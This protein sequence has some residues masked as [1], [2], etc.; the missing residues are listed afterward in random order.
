MQKVLKMGFTVKVGLLLVLAGVA[1][2]LWFGQ[3]A[4]AQLRSAGVVGTGTPASCTESAFT[5]TLA[6]GGSLTFNCG[7]QPFT[8]TL[9]QRANVV[10]NTVIDG[11]GLATISGGNST[12]LFDV[13]I[14]NSVKFGIQNLTLAN[15]LSPDQGAA[16][17]S[18][19]GTTLT[20]TNSIFINNVT[21]AATTGF[22]GGGAIFLDVGATGS[23]VGSSFINNTAGNG[24]AIKNNGSLTVNGSTFVGNKSTASGIGASSNGGGG[25]LYNNSGNLLVSSSVI[26]KNSAIFQGGGIMSFQAGPNANLTTV[27][28]TTLANNSVTGGAAT[29]GFGGGIYNGAGPL[30]LSNSAL[31]G[32]NASNQG[33]GIWHSDAPANFTNVTF[34]NNQAVGADGMRGLGGGIFSTRSVITNTNVTIASNYAGFQGGGVA[35]DTNIIFRNTIIANNIG[36]NNGL[37][38]NVKNN[39]TNTYTNGGNNLQFPP[40][41]PNNPDD[42]D[43]APNIM[44][45]DPRLGLPLNNG[46]LTPTLAL[47]GGSPAIDAGNSALCPP[48]DQRGA[49]RVNVCDIG[50]FEYGANLPTGPAAPTYTYYLPFL[51]ANYAPSGQTGSFTTYLVFQNVGTGTAAI[52]LQYFDNNGASINTPAATCR[53]VQQN[54]ECIAPNPFAN[55]ARGSGVLVSTQPLNVVVAQA[56]PFGGSAYVVGAGAGSQLIAPLAINNNGGFQTQLTVFNGGGSPASVTVTFYDKNGQAAPATSTK[57]LQIAANTSQSLNQAAADSG[58]PADFYGWAQINGP[59]NS[60]LVAQVLEQNPATH[61]VAIANAQTTAH[62]TLYAPAIFNGAFGGFVTGANIVNPNPTPVNVTVTYDDHT[63]IITPTATFVLPAFA[64]QPIFHGSNV[65]GDGLPPGGLP[66]SFYGA[67]TVTATGGGVVMVVNEGGGLTATG[68]AKSGVYSAAAR[69]SNSVGLPVLANGGFGYVTGATI[70]NTSNATVNG[71]IQYYNID[72]TSQGNA[73]AF[74]IA[75]FASQVAYQGD[76]T[77]GLPGPTSPTPFYGTAIVTET[78]SGND[79][80]VTTNAQSQAFF[81]TYTEPSS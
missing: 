35:G 15:A 67:A 59:A 78:S 21:T 12:G 25:A 6:L 47:G 52:S 54:G 31:V 61:F 50:A 22:D 40:K 29:Q 1:A 30:L 80:I 64:I 53:L 23:V 9:T 72:G 66:S 60:Q 18:E 32:N 58:L 8:L 5:T 74:S 79:L 65:G 17:K 49:V 19:F 77:Q 3:T 28:S 48:T 81:Y 20:V 45:A 51:A 14:T 38:Y 42:I 4:S 7:S 33:G 41:N 62:T 63:G 39:C 37:G 71:S 16:I 57:T 13:T 24:G 2:G 55:N 36:N 76:P 56:T 34:A 68:S 75:P 73:K 10:T 46:G 11:G 44:V 70:L 27:V 43:C 69:G 26:S